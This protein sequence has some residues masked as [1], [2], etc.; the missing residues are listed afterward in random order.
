M[1]LFCDD[2]LYCVFEKLQTNLLILCAISSVCK[3]WKRVSQPLLLNAKI[4][5]WEQLKDRLTSYIYN[6][7]SWNSFENFEMFTKYDWNSNGCLAFCHSKITTSGTYRE[8]TVS[9]CDETYTQ[10]YF[11]PS[12]V[13]LVDMHFITRLQELSLFRSLKEDIAF[14]GGVREIKVEGKWKNEFVTVTCKGYSP[15]GCYVKKGDEYKD[16]S[17]HINWTN[18]TISLNNALYS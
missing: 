6:C 11:E 17:S 18:A 14:T 16:V 5:H 7:H 13:S 8:E 9:F 15:I 1:R 2:D 4:E 12:L 3:F 10:L